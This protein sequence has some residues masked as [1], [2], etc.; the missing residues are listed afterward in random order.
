M[1][2]FKK[3]LYLIFITCIIL[4]IFATG[5]GE[6]IK[7]P[8]DVTGFY[9]WVEMVQ[10][11]IPETQEIES[12]NILT[13]QDA[14]LYVIP[15]NVTRIHVN[16]P[17]NA[18]L[19]R[20]LDVHNLYDN[21]STGLSEY[22]GWYYW[23]FPDDV[24]REVSSHA[25]QN[26]TIDFQEGVFDDSKINITDNQIKLQDGVNSGEYVSPGIVINGTEISSAKISLNS[27]YSN[28]FSYFLSNDNGTTWQPWVNNSYLE[29][30]DSG[31]ILKYKLNITGNS[32]IRPT[33]DLVIMDYEYVPMATTMALMA[34]YTIES[35][36]EFSFEKELL[37]DIGDS[38]IYIYVEDDY[39]IESN[40]V[41]W[42]D[43]D[44]PN[45]TPTMKDKY[46]GKVL[47]VG[48]VEP[49]SIFS[50][51]MNPGED[52]GND[53]LF[54]F[55]FIGLIL[56]IVISVIYL[57]KMGDGPIEK[58]DD[59]DKEPDDEEE[60][61]SVA[62]EKSDIEDVKPVD[63]EV[64]K[65]RKQKILTALKNLDKDYEDG[66]I[67]EESYNEIKAKYRQE[68]INVMKELDK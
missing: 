25:I 55:A 45:I 23:E 1:M 51:T 9:H 16:I 58:T 21:V 34:E 36:P 29:F 68:A 35:N 59:T 38:V 5:M 30:D 63:K 7:P 66:I 14:M 24:S 10:G 62:H 61:E 41:T 60:T 18:N 17:S 31:D 42:V 28:Y 19:T 26:E 33:V 20:I 27:T 22:P 52:S 56:I 64:L 44:D 8:S 67:S 4:S 43:P 57:R 65:V 53:S 6:G 47:H 13:V 40:N 11:D 49:G 54:I 12:E 39:V 46:P 50:I 15:W 32:T 3:T 37:Y 2:A 48:T